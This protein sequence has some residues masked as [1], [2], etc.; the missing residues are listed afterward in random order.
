VHVGVVGLAVLDGGGGGVVIGLP[1]HARHDRAHLGGSLLFLAGTVR[2]DPLAG[3]VGSKVGLPV[4]DEDEAGVLRV[5]L[6]TL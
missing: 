6:Y 2:G 3:V 5:R 1:P 4:G